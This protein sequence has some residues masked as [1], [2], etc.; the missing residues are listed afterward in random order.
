MALDADT[1]G[2]TM[3]IGYRE[4][5]GCSLVLS[6]EPKYVLTRD[7]LSLHASWDL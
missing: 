7:L 4:T 1:P 6:F 3:A 2:M 5:A